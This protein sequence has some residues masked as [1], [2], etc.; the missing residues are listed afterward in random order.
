MKLTGSLITQTLLV[1]GER[2]KITYFLLKKLKITIFNFT[3]CSYK[4]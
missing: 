1:D 4:A 3:L 2:G